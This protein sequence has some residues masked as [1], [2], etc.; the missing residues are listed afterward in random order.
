LK[1]SFV[2][3][4]FPLNGLVLCFQKLIQCRFIVLV[5]SSRLP[6][7]ARPRLVLLIIHSLSKV[8]I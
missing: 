7:T 4:W 5:W 3:N 6:G 2:K 1:S 8:V